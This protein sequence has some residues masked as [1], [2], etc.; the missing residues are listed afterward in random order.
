[1]GAG[2][3]KPQPYIPSSSPSILIDSIWIE[4]MDGSPYQ[5]HGDTLI[6]HAIVSDSSGTIDTGLID[7]K[8]YGVCDSVTGNHVPFILDG[9]N[10]PTYIVDYSTDSTKQGTYTIVLHA[11]C[12]GFLP[13][14]KTIEF[15]A[16]FFKG[17]CSGQ[18]RHLNRHDKSSGL[19]DL[20]MRGTTGDIAGTDDDFLFY[21]RPVKENSFKVSTKIKGFENMATTGAKAGVMIRSLHYSGDPNVFFGIQENNTLVF[22][23]RLSSG[24]TTTTHSTAGY[25]VGNTW[26]ALKKIF[27]K[28]YGFV[29]TD[30][31]YYSLVDSVSISVFNVPDVGFAFS[32]NDTAMWT[33]GEPWVVLGNMDIAVID[34]L[35]ALPVVYAS[36]SLITLD[37]VQLNAATLGAG[38][39]LS[40]NMDCIINGNIKVDGDAVFRN[41]S[42]SNGT[43]TLSGNLTL[44]EGATHNGPLYEGYNVE[45]DT[46][47]EKT[48]PVGTY[49]IYIGNGKTRTLSGGGTYKDIT[50]DSRGLLILNAG[51]YNMRSF[52]LNPDAKLTINGPVEINVNSS[53]SLDDRVIL[54]VSSINNAKIYTNDTFFS[55]G[56]MTF[57]GH[58]VAPNA[59]ITLKSR[60]NYRGSIKGKVLF[61]DNDAK[62][63]DY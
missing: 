49:S 24:G 9:H 10:A 18:P 22:Q 42:V 52:I 40:S 32:R 7:F 11:E 53:L 47:P 56:E 57:K 39:G 48:V 37:R 63:Y 29:S 38:V 45:F 30:G 14:S 35:E 61:F 41:R 16:W 20:R 54:T 55:I 4:K 5:I 19:W 13:A 26:V 43:M 46:I 59:R 2:T 36:D 31:V 8:W 25:Y 15:D 27:D 50:V 44:I 33:A 60:I 17:I 28:V 58:V 23:Y 12:P 3:F 1:M 62:L 51:T 34:T 6:L 21:Y